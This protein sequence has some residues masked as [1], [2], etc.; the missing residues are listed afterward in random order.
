[1]LI[2]P[3]LPLFYIAILKTR[4]LLTQKDFVQILGISRSYLANLEAGQTLPTNRLIE[5]IS[6]KFKIPQEWLLDDESTDLEVPENND[7]LSISLVCKYNLLQDEYKYF[8]LNQIEQLLEI[9]SK[10]SNKKES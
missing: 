10:L 1:M 9:Q 6:L 3:L 5:H 4:Q 7:F 2:I 8:I